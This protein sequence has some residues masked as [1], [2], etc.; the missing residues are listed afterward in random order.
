MSP[1][2][3]FVSHSTADDAF[4]AEME[5]FLRAAGF[6]DVFNDVSAIQP[7]EEFW[8]KTEEGITNCDSFFV[9]ITLRPMRRNG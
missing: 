9:V 8:P 5:L 3:A 6:D 7:D 1:R 4:V 2:R